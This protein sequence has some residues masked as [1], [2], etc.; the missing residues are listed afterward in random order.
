MRRPGEPDE[1][2]EPVHLANTKMMEKFKA[3]G[4]FCL[5]KN[6]TNYGYHDTTMMILHATKRR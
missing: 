4:A 1:H 2:G 5:Q 6:Q 3:G